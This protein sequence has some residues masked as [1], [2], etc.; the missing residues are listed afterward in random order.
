MYT[1]EIVPLGAG[2]G[3]RSQEIKSSRSAWTASHPVS[4]EQRMLSVW[5]AVLILNAYY[6]TFLNIVASR[7]FCDLAEPTVFPQPSDPK[8]F[9]LPLGSLG[10]GD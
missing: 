6:S 8:V 1:P 2:D 7:M 4:I 9:P 3:G 5:L 10:V